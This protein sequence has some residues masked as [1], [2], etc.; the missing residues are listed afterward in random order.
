MEMKLPVQRLHR[1]SWL[2]AVIVSIIIYATLS[3]QAS[4]GHR[5]LFAFETLICI[6][7]IGHT[8]VLIMRALIS[9][10][11]LI[12]TRRFN[13]YRLL[14]S[15]PISI[16]IYLLLWPIFAHFSNQLWSY[17]DFELLFTFIGG[18]SVV[19]TMVFVLHDSVLLYQHKLYS[20]L[21]LARLNVSNAEAANLLL[22]QQIQPHFLF[23]AITTLKAL[24]HTD[25]N[26]A[27][28]YIVHM[29]D[30]L[31]AS[32]FHQSSK[33]IS[34]EEELTLLCDYLEMQKIRFGTALDCKVSLSEDIIKGYCLP[35]FSLQ[36]LLEN[37]IKHNE[38]TTATPLV[39]NITNSG[40]WLTVSNNLQKKKV[41]SPSTSFGLAN[42]SERYRLL[43]GDE[44][45]INETADKFEII[46]KLLKNGYRNY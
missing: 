9:Q 46:I 42:L 31:R 41:K 34:V 40:D 38:F 1:L 30:F 27:D 17:D 23:N 16:A 4:H 25:T 29:A 19:N 32:I 39:V 8:D 37:A 35:S 10:K 15:Y 6:S 36:P 13:R 26:I 20:E 5:V 24:Y 44:V 33:I 28:K 12:R 7:L 43:S 21:E 2:L 3:E 11:I 14:F 45:I 18:A 22:K